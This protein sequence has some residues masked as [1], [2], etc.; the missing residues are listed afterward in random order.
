MKE[1]N[2]KNS[3]PLI[4]ELNIEVEKLLKEEDFNKWII[5]IQNLI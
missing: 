5:F 3:Y 4:K 1:S 2:I